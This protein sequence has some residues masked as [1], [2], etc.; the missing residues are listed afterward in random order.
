M[1]RRWLR[2]RVLS[3]REVTL[4]RAPNEKLPGASAFGLAALFHA[5]DGCRARLSVD[6]SSGGTPRTGHG[7]R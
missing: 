2:G 5:S 1:G 6:C 3:H 7:A 4:E